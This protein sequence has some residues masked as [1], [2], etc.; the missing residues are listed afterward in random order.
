MCMENYVQ[1]GTW[2]C[3]MCSTEVGKSS[4]QGWSMLGCMAEPGRG[5]KWSLIAHD[6]KSPH[7]YAGM[8]YKEALL[9]NPTIG[10]IRATLYSKPILG[11]CSSIPSSSIIGLVVNPYSPSYMLLGIFPSALLATEEMS[12]SRIK[13]LQYE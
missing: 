6:E 3:P 7:I 10:R 11:P 13:I 8:G 12:V 9:C 5:G 4:K 2:S 1:H